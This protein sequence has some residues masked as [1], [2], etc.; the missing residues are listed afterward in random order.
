MVQN[1]EH[2][3]ATMNTAGR[4]QIVCSVLISKWRKV[5]TYWQNIEHVVYEQK[6]Y[7]DVFAECYIPCDSL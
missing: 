3:V 7:K 2:H 5:L 1:C 6:V 4:A